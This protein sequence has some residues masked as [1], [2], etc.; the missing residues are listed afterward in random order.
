MEKEAQE[1]EAGGG[2][3]EQEA[4]KKAACQ[5]SCHGGPCANLHTWQHQ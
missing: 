2:S 4:G 5:R 1:T 3:Q